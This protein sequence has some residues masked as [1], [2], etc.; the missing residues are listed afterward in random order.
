GAGW[1]TV[2][3]LLVLVMA[4]PASA[5]AQRVHLLPTEAAFAATPSTAVPATAMTVGPSLGWSELGVGAAAAA[6]RGPAPPRARPGRGGRRWGGGGPAP[7]LSA[8]APP[9]LLLAAVLPP[10]A[11]T[12]AEVLMGNALSPGHASFFPAFWAGLGTQVL[13]LTASI[14]LGATVGSLMSMA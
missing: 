11:V 14:V 4:S 2:A 12:L 9:P 13:A 5:S 6:G 8:A 7:T 10:L 1:V 3:A